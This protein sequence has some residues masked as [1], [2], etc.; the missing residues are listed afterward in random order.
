MED[1]KQNLYILEENTLSSANL[2]NF[3]N[4]RFNQLLNISIFL[5]NQNLLNKIDSETAIVIIDFNLKGEKTEKILLDIKKINPNTEVI[6]LSTNEEIGTAID[7]FR[8]GAKSIII[9]GEKGHRALFSVIYKILNYPV[10]ILIEQ[11]GIN[12]ILA[13][14]IAYIF[15][16]GIIVY[17]GMLLLQA[18]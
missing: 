17:L 10:K 18:K 6:V 12:K 8:K 14:F 15:I 4:K 9:K 7:V 2:M 13:I 11:F 16:I 3:L 1:K 5:D